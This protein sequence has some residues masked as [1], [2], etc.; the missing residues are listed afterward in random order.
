MKISYEKGNKGEKDRILKITTEKEEWFSIYKLAVLIN[1]LTINEWNINSD[2]IKQT[3][4]FFFRQAIEDVMTMGEEG[5][6]WADEKNIELVKVWCKNY[7]L[8]FEKIEPELRKII[9]T[10]IE[11]F[12]K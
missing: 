9:Q 12:Q 7:F 11:D 6:D 8:K 1:Q 2:K 3:G 4:N 10:K 5:T